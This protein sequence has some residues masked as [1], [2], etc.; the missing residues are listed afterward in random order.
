MDLVSGM[1]GRVVALRHVSVDMT[2]VVVHI[3]LSLGR[4]TLDLSKQFV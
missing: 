4:L 2:T 3:K 1:D